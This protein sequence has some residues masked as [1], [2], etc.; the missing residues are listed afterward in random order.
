MT[1]PIDEQLLRNALHDA[2]RDVE[3]APGAKERVLHAAVSRV[4]PDGDEPDADDTTPTV[5]APR[6]R[7]V[8][9]PLAAAAA[10]LLAAALI[11][12]LA[13]SR[14][15][16]GQPL[17]FGP[18]SQRVDGVASPALPQN[19]AWSTSH[20]LAFTTLGAPNLAPAEASG[21]VLGAA[22][23]GTTP[24]TVATSA[25]VVAVGTIAMKVPS[26]K[27][28]QVLGEFTSLAAQDGGYV[29]SSKVNA[30]SGTST[31]TATIV[32]RV[33]QHQFGSLVTAVQRYGTPTSVVTNSSDVTGEF[34]DYEA[35]IAALEA[36][37]TQYLAILARASSISDILAVQAQINDIQSQIEQLKGA[38]NVLVNEAAYSTLT[39]S[40]NSG[41][42][43]T[44]A[45]AS[46]LAT[47]WDDSI[48]GFVRGFEWVVRAAGPALF[49]LLCLLVLFALG[50]L[51]WRATRRRML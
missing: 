6:R 30:G 20:S 4:A 22:P 25:K 36:S 27:L 40:L 43:S 10:V 1:D 32:L 34:V 3:P 26:S 31:S 33:P 46:G 23:A 51:G 5:V 14:P 39:I 15:P 35:R 41:P 18:L 11:V 44:S 2:V 29:A 37:R 17:S 47:A 7:R 12:S 21:K 9:L 50:R 19:N 45:R 24:A 49:A 28:Q 38:R 16:A 13:A 48:G 42:G 8:L